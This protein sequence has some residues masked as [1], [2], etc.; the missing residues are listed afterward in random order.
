[1]QP[2]SIFKYFSQKPH[3]DTFLKNGEV[4]FNTLSYFLSCEDQ[5]RRDV[6]EDANIY[7]P[8]SGLDITMTAT[9]QK[10]KDYRGLISRVKRPDRV[11]VFCASIELSE[12]LFHKFG[13]VG[14]VEIF[15][16]QEFSSRITRHL[17]KS[18]HNIKNREIL[19]GKIEYYGFEEEPEARYACPDQIIMSKSSRFSD[20][21]EYRVAFAKDVDAFAV[22]NVN[23]TLTD[24]L[25]I[26]A[27]TGVPKK[28]ILGDLSD[29]AKVVM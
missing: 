14:C 26:N 29:I 21:K 25:E 15:D 5:A 10:L 7:M 20:E 13:A 18:A 4:F 3:L 19:S 22:N 17:R 24:T 28:L 12:N 27:A 6:T 1:M 16:V 23:H 8:A 2:S 9:N 11:F